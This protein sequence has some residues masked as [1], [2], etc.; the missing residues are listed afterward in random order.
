MRGFFMGTCDIK[1]SE[2]V[3]TNI[4]KFD[5]SSHELR[6]TISCMMQQVAI[7]NRPRGRIGRHKTGVDATHGGRLNG[8]VFIDHEDVRDYMDLDECLVLARRRVASSKSCYEF[9]K[10]F[11]DPR[12]AKEYARSHYLNR[13]KYVM[14][15]EVTDSHLH[16]IPL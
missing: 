9:I 11:Y 5:F 8:R 3:W 6:A 16:D 7:H 14:L 4:S 10:S 15:L 2:S 13:D 12:N 1:G